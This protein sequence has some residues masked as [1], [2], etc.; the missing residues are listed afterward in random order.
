[1]LSLFYHGCEENFLHKSPYLEADF[2]VQEHEA[3][4]ACLQ[5][6]SYQGAVRENPLFRQEC[7]RL[8]ALRQLVPLPNGSNSAVRQAL[9]EQMQDILDLEADIAATRRQVEAWEAEASDPY[10]DAEM[11]RVRLLRAQMEQEAEELSARID[12]IERGNEQLELAC[13]QLREAQASQDEVI[14]AL[15]EVVT[16]FEEAYEKARRAAKK[17]KRMQ[18][19]AFAVNAVTCFATGAPFFTNLV[20]E[21]GRCAVREGIS[22][23]IPQAQFAAV[24]AGGI[25]GAIDGGMKGMIRGGMMPVVD[26]VSA[27]VLGNLGSGVTHAL[28]DQSFVKKPQYTKAAALGVVGGGVSKATGVTVDF[29]PNG[30]KAVNMHV[31]V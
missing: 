3:A 27:K 6:L 24:V 8:F 20:R 18:L 15:K 1:M 25:N 30:K 7:E 14:A 19:V 17:Q 11:E 16:K 21:A 4:S 22:E 28:V 12:E 2:F 10:V 26:E 31:R 13:E 5:W 9:W 23:L 29:T